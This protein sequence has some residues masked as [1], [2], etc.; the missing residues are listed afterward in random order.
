MNQFDEIP[1]RAHDHEPDPDCLGDLDEFAL[2]GFGASVQEESPV[3]QEIPRDV[4]Q[5][6]E[7]I[8]HSCCW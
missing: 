1:N 5:F 2:V 4:G 8:G 3:S 7:L 6:L